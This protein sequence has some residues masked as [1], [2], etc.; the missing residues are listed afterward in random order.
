MKLTIQHIK[1]EIFDTKTF[2]L[3]A[4][5]SV[6]YKSG[7]FLTLIFH[8]QQTE[9][10]RSYSLGST[11]FVDENLFITIKR[12]VNGEISRRLFD[13]AHIGDILISLEPAGKFIIEEPV[14]K[15]YCFIAAGSGITPCFALIKELLFFHQQTKIILINQCRSEEEI[16]YKHE[17]HQLKHVF[18]ERFE[19]IELFSQPKFYPNISKRLNNEMLEEIV[20]QTDL[21]NQTSNISFYLCGPTSFMRMAQFTLKR[22]GFKNEQIRKEIFVVDKPPLPPFFTDTS[23]KKLTIYFQKNMHQIEVAY[24]QTILNAA[25][26]KNIQLPYSCKAGK[27]SACMALCISGKIKMSNNEVLTEKDL[28]KGFVLTCVGY[29]ETDVVLNFDEK[30]V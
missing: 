30:D 2:F 8:Q 6:S 16:I 10:R 22:I 21:R 29:A 24:P 17:L 25:L 4:K 23:L 1:Q 5:N 12:K 20:L 18:F 26:Q 19:L 3:L 27:C 9:I 11:P 7:Q 14:S 15:I 13:H 28:E